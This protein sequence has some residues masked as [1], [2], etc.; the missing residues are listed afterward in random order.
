VVSIKEF[1][2][3]IESAPVGARFTYYRG[4]LATDCGNSVRL[5]VAVRA[6]AGDAYSSGEVTLTQKR[7]GDEFEYIAIK[8]NP[9]H[10]GRR[11]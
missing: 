8:S 6:I 2:E 7:V 11:R 1:S 9:E 4:H 3:F 5:A 10:R